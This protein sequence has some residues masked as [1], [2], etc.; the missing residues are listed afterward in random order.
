MPL[1]DFLFQTNS[2]KFPGR[3]LGHMR[4][5]TKGMKHSM[6]QITT[7]VSYASLSS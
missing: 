6:H 5:R 7:G 4:A 3:T 1:Q 2:G